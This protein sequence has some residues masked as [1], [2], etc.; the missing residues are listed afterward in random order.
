MSELLD[1][2]KELFFS[3]K[4]LKALLTVAFAVAFSAAMFVGA[5]LAL[6]LARRY[7]SRFAVVVGV[8]AGAGGFGVLDG[9]RLMRDIGPR[10]WMWV[11]VGAAAGGVL[12]F[13][14]SS[15]AERPMRLAIGTGGGALL[16]LLIGVGMDDAIHPAIAW[17]DLILW[18]VIGAVAGGAVGYFRSR[19]TD[20]AVRGVILGAGL[21]ALFGGW[22]GADLGEGSAGEAILLTLLAG[23]LLGL[24]TGMTERRDPAEQKQFAERSRAVVFVLPAMVFIIGGLVLPL[25]RTLVVSFRNARNDGWVGLRNY[26][27][28]F[29]DEKSVNFSN[30][31][32]IFS[33]QL[34]YL[35]LALVVLGYAFGVVGGKRTGRSF[36]AGGSSLG[37]LIIGLFLLACAILANIRGTI[38]NNVWWVIVVTFVTTSMGLAVAVLADKAKFEKAAKALVFLPMAISF[39]GAG[40]IWR[41]MYQTR[42]V[43]K[44]Q[45]GLLN[46]IWVALG[47]FTTHDVGK[48][49]S[50]VVLLTLIAGCAYLGYV[51]WRS[52]GAGLLGSGIGLFLPLLYLLVRVLGGGYGGLPG[53]K[54]QDRAIEFINTSPW[55]NIWLMIILI[56]IQT[57][58]AMV[59]FSAAIR[60]V[61][62][63]LVEAARIDGASESQAFWRVIVPQ[64]LPTVGVVATTLILLVMKVFDIV[65]VTTNGNFDTQVIAN[66]MWQRSFRENNR[67]LGSALAITLF[68]TVIP[69]MIYNIR[70]MQEERE[71]A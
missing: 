18:L 45:T 62:T 15:F 24:G 23:V 59:I 48:W 67:G 31:D 20:G 63:E 35:A 43:E 36:E 6:N 38:F 13:V 60:S 25:I 41:F 29:T 65:S 55:N 56:W 68:I 40:I 5:N 32:K 30:W 27:T 8:L 46:A 16:G 44:E 53:E 2:L 69:V 22:G 66:D 11:L 52:K 3:G 58:F 12:A 49:V 7:W 57:G 64:I 17:G 70:R 9:N 37:P 26:K 28:I 1:T 51:G 50:V 39:V 71:E 19:A 34:F 61:P 14:L 42:N 4:T 54:E 21:G 10:P 33:S 47:R